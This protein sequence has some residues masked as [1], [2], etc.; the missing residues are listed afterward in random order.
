VVLLG[1]RCRL[2][3]GQVHIGVRHDGQRRPVRPCATLRQPPSPRGHTRARRFRAPALVFEGWFSLRAQC[4]EC[5]FPFERGEEEDYWIGAFL[6]N[7]IV[8]EVIFAALLLGVLVAT[9][10]T[11]PWSPLIWISA[12]QMIVAPIVF[13][14]FSKALWLAG[15]LWS[16]A[17]RPPRTSRRGTT[18][19]ATREHV[20]ASARTRLAPGTTTAS[21]TSTRASTP[22]ASTR[23]PRSYASTS[24]RTPTRS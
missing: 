22:T 23:T 4:R 16:F 18:G 13:Y 20:S 9:W 24:R 5:G 2:R 19:T 11:P 1:R 15:D 3:S 21:A 17:R 14:P 12:I 7:F 6:L 10:P 8:T